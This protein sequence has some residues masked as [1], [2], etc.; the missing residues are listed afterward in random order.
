MMNNY[1]V[2]AEWLKE[3]LEDADL[4][5]IDSRFSLQDPSLG[6]KQYEEQH[7]P[8]AY[9]FD[10]NTDLSSTP[11]KHGGRHPLPNISEF[12]TKLSAIG[13][14]S[15][16][17][18]LIVAY[19]NSR[20]A[21]ASRFW[22]LMRFLGHEGV[23]LLDGGF[24]AWKQKGYPV[25]SVLPVASS[26]NFVP[27][28]NY[29]WIVDIEAVKERKDLPGVVLVDSRA[30]ERYLGEI[31]PI[32]PIAGHIPGAIN[33]PWQEVTDAKGNIQPVEYQQNRWKNL[34]NSEEI[35][36]YCGSGVTA[37]VNLLSLTIAGIDTTKLYAGSWSDWCSYQK[38]E[39]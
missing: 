36:V 25:T 16:N 8:G 2:S 21:F 35:I 30:R 32:D 33:Y 10:L 26:G 34:E 20:L 15:D 13:V 22:W 39:E 18:S 5:V 17:P 9:Y 29:D 1:I 7:I 11:Q 37:C 19:D 3:H 24:D 28:P 12:V 14:Q 27:N 6:R 38:D 31:E 23:V 4:I